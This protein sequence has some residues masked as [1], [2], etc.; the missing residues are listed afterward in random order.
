[1]DF[2][3]FKKIQK[4]IEDISKPFTQQFDNVNH[5]K[6]SNGFLNNIFR[7]SGVIPQPEKKIK[8]PSTSITVFEPSLSSTINDSNDDTPEEMINEKSKRHDYSNNNNRTN[9]KDNSQNKS[10]NSESESESDDDHYEHVR[11]KYTQVMNMNIDTKIT[12]NI[13]LYFTET[14]KDRPYTLFLLNKKSDF[15]T[16][17]SFTYDK[18]LYNNKNDDHSVD[19][20]ESS[21]E[22]ISP[23][24]VEIVNKCIST[25]LKMQKDGISLNTKR[26]LSKNTYIGYI[27]DKQR[28]N[29]TVILNGDIVYKIFDANE[30]KSEYVLLT[31]DEIVNQKLNSSTEI[32][33]TVFEMYFDTEKLDK[34]NETASSLSPLLSTKEPIVLYPCLIKP[35]NRMSTLMNGGNPFTNIGNFI[36][37]TLTNMVGQ[38]KKNEDNNESDSDS[39]NNETNGMSQSTIPNVM[40][41]SII[42]AT[43]SSHPLYPVL[44]SMYF[45]TV[46]PP[47]D[48]TQI[49]K[50][51][52]FYDTTKDVE[53]LSKIEL[54]E[55]QE[56]EYHP[57]VSDTESESS[58]DGEIRDNSEL[59]SGDEKSENETNEIDESGDLASDAD[60]ESG[61][62]ASDA[63]DESGEKASDAED[64]SGE[65]A[66]DAEDESGDLASDAAI[67]EASDAED[68]SGDLASDAEDESGEEASDAEDESGDL[69][70]DAEDESGEEADTKKEVVKDEIQK[71]EDSDESDEEKKSEE[72]DE[73]TNKRT[74]E[75]ELDSDGS[76]EVNK[77]QSNSSDTESSKSSNSSTS[78]SSSS[79][80]SESDND[81][82][83]D[84]DDIEESINDTVSKNSTLKTLMS[85]VTKGGGPNQTKRIIE[86]EVNNTKIIGISSTN[87]LIFDKM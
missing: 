16:F 28:D 43:E 59:D 56:S 45:F 25:V 39:D 37:S 24:H 3:G 54:D 49:S 21:I 17:P 84:P 31:R 55:T 7:V 10:N 85:F 47:K 20:D 4:R 50:Y 62:L 58:E 79:S 36:N 76:E 72:E 66:S 44:G 15:Y 52:A 5:G 29:L 11:D 12:V 22:D 78:S 42:E 63:E 41:E 40:I 74:L 70:S 87:D 38:T 75:E 1:M 65:K 81:T 64:E 73:A 26:K 18:V 13:V 80:S 77:N 82:H 60:D 53:V 57:I 9:L 69:A 67:K 2:S 51:I 33:P 14:W 71:H 68:E 30:K 23:Q 6:E 48:A 83:F 61:D 86:F 35:D 46:T 19:S 34:N 32:D 27:H 8:S